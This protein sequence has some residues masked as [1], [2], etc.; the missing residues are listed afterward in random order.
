MVGKQSTSS[1]CSF[2]N[3]TMIFCRQKQHDTVSPRSVSYF[4]PYLKWYTN[5]AKPSEVSHSGFTQSGCVGMKQLCCPST[6][7]LT[8]CTHLMPST[9]SALLPPPLPTRALW[10]SLGAALSTRRGRNRRPPRTMSS[11]PATDSTAGGPT[12]FLG[13]LLGFDHYHSKALLLCQKELYHTELTASDTSE[14]TWTLKLWLK[15]DGGIQHFIRD[16][17]PNTLLTHTHF[18]TLFR[19]D[20]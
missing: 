13:E 1:P 14:N 3:S 2:F 16:S 7:T 12:I 15:R 10:R 11:Q 20:F 6:Q 5:S 17:A 19:T 8:P 9:L 4:R 18:F